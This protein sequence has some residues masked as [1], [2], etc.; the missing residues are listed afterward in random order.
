MVLGL[1]YGVVE[2]WLEIWRFVAVHDDKLFSVAE[3][4]VFGFVTLEIWILNLQK[5]L[6]LIYGKF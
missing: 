5:G 6:G 1:L 3:I 4:F 2:F